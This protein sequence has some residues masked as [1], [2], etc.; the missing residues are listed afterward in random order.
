MF[1]IKKELVLTAINSSDDKTKFSD[2]KGVVYQSI[3]VSIMD[4]SSIKIAF[5]DNELKNKPVYKSFSR[6]DSVSEFK[7]IINTLTSE[8]VDLTDSTFNGF[9][10]QFKN[11][12]YLNS[13]NTI[14]FS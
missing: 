5:T 8:N 13:N 6:I 9:I 10:K 3:W 1:T 7:I 11:V 14:Q 4:N 2:E 12:I